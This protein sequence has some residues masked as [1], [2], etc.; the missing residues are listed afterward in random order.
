MVE[1]TIAHELTHAALM[2]LSLPAWVEEGFAQMFEH[3][4]TGRALL[5]MNDEMGQAHKNWWGEHG[6]EAFWRGDGFHQ[7]GD[8]QRL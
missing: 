4:M 5:L 2:Y 8:G 1:N 6:L 7:T 3:D